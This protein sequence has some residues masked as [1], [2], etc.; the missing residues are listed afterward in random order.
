MSDSLFNLPFVDDSPEAREMH[1]AT[2]RL[3]ESIRAYRK[4]KPA[5]GTQHFIGKTYGASFD[6]GD[7]GGVYFVLSPLP[8]R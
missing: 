6:V 8:E 5:T 3:I 2:V 4:A 7:G 1:E